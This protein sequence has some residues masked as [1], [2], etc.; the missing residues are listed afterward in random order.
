M[1]NLLL[2]C[3]GKSFPTTDAFVNCF[4]IKYEINKQETK[5]ETKHQET[6]HLFYFQ[7]RESLAPS[8]GV[9]FKLRD[10]F[11]RSTLK[12]LGMTSAT[13]R[14]LYCRIRRSS[15]IWKRIARKSRMSGRSLCRHDRKSCLPLPMP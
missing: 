15:R 13:Q 9:V 4:E 14:R 5:Q 6:S 8:T 2:A 7:V 3:F 1:T 10:L 12:I 11:L